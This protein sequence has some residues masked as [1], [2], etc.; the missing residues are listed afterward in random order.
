MDEEH[1]SIRLKR[2]WDDGTTHVVLTFSELLERLAAL[3]PR[4]GSH[5]VRYHGIL[6]S[7]ARHRRL[8]VP[9][10]SLADDDISSEDDTPETETDATVSPSPARR[11]RR[12]LWAELLVR[13]FGPTSDPLSCEKCGGRMR[14]LSSI[15]KA[16]VIEKILACLGLPSVPPQARPA[17]GPPDTEMFEFTWSAGEWGC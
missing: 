9:R 1:V 12:M 7:R 4:P 2:P 8:V 17:R 6:A 15:H 11:F 5:R 14:V 10:P 16:D 3:V 13:V